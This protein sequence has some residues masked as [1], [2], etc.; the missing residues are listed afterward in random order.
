MPSEFF[1]RVL[2]VVQ[3]FVTSL[4]SVSG[5]ASLSTQQT[6]G[7]LLL[8]IL[9]AVNEAATADDGHGLVPYERFYNEAVSDLV[10]LRSHYRLWKDQPNVF[11]FCRYP[12]LFTPAA[13]SVLLGVDSQAQMITHSY[14][15][16]RA[17]A[18]ALVAPQTNMTSQT[19]SQLADAPYLLLA[20]RR[21]HLV[22]D[23]LDQLCDRSSAK[24]LKR[25]LRV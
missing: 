24:D 13:K 10:D 18:E 23:T 14:E 6:S 15:S 7:V 5:I 8:E 17:V 16:V 20:V 4:L 2:Q 25:P 22:D 11:S 1:S 21:S 12:F 3:G 9:H 19:L